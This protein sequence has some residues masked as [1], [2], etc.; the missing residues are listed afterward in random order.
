[1]IPPFRS[2]SSRAMTGYVL[3]N[4]SWEWHMRRVRASFFPVTVL[5]LAINAHMRRGTFLLCIQDNNDQCSAVAQHCAQI[6]DRWADKKTS[7][8]GSS[9][10]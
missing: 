4:G 3:C 8:L 9:M 2:V 7:M 5:V 10:S 1:M 6:R